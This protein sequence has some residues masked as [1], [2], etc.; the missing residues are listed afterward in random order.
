[1]REF[2]LKGGEVVVVKVYALVVVPQPVLLKLLFVY[3][4]VL[5]YSIVQVTQRVLEL[6]LLFLLGKG[7]VLLRGVAHVFILRDEVVRL[8]QRDVRNPGRM[9]QVVLLLDL[10]TIVFHL[11]LVRF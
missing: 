11:Y 7:P 1:M 6:R 5:V 4:L 9:G 10:V 3:I 2:K 8:G